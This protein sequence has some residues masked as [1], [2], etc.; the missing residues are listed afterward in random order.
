MGVNV[1]RSAHLAVIDI[2]LAWLSAWSRIARVPIQVPG[3]RPTLVVLAVH[4]NGVVVRQSIDVANR[5]APVADRSE[6][7]A[8]LRVDSSQTSPSNRDSSVRRRLQFWW[9]TGT[10]RSPVRITKLRPVPSTSKATTLQRFTMCERWTL[11]NCR[12]SRD[13][14]RLAID[15]LGVRASSDLAPECSRTYWL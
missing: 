10:W 14:A 7:R 8:E 5:A 2:P 9:L 13:L 11:K 15:R 12:G 3:T 4:E 6:A 1:P